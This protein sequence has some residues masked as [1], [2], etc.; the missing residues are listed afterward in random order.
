MQKG[1]HAEIYPLVGNGEVELFVAAWLPNASAPDPTRVIR[2]CS[3]AERAVVEVLLSVGASIYL[4]DD[5]H[6]R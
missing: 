3:Q 1:S 6:V 2:A 4:D 5:G